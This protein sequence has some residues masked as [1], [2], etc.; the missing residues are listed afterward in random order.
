MMT[1]SARA[2]SYARRFPKWPAPRV[3]ERWL[4]TVWMLGNNY[5]GSGFYGSYPPGY[6]QRV[7]SLFPDA[8]N[9]L[10]VFSGSLTAEQVHEAWVKANGK[11]PS[12]IQMRYDVSADYSPDILGNAEDLSNTIR[13][14]MIKIPKMYDLIL[15]DP[16]YSPADAKRYG[17]PMPNRTKVLSEIAAVCQ[18][19]SNLVWLDTMLP[20]FRKREWHLWGL[21][22]LVRSTNHRVRLASVF[23]RT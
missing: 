2:E 6:L 17:T 7:F 20:M 12:P 18:T 23:R 8:E 22:C 9:V 5:K 1:P 11:E 10:H 16:P 4:D 21:I 13:T 3:D 14:C 19:G 15:A